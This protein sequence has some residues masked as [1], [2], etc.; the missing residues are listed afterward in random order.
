[1]HMIINGDSPTAYYLEELIRIDGGELYHAGS[2][3]ELSDKV[4]TVYYIY[5]SSRLSERLDTDDI[6]RLEKVS[7]EK[8]VRLVFVINW[9]LFNGVKRGNLPIN[10]GTPPSPDSISGINQMWVMEFVKVMSKRN[11]NISLLAYPTSLS[12]HHLENGFLENENFYLYDKLREIVEDFRLGVP[13][14]LY[15]GDLRVYYDIIHSADIANVVYNMSKSDMSGVYMISSQKTYTLREIVGMVNGIFV[16]MFESL[17]LS[18]CNVTVKKRRRSLNNYDTYM[19]NMDSWFIR[20]QSDDSTL[21]ETL[22]D[23]I[24]EVL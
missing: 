8:G 16:R 9:N 5:D 3:R 10:R 7:A 1:M 17:R 15:E 23:V 13:T 19:D 12:P 22:V 11:K 4:S 24:R 14:T 21:M 6:I 2:G 20:L 18:D